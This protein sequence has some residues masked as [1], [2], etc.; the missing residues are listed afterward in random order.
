[1]EI[2]DLNIKEF[3]R[4]IKNLVKKFTPEEL[5]QELIACGLNKKG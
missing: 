4:E 5:L 1:M 3:E 2:F